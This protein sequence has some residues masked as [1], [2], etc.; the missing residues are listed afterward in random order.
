[1][2]NWRKFGRLPAGEKLVFLS[3]L[4][5]LPA[6]RLGL[7]LLGLRRVL[8]LL[9]THPNYGT[10]MNPGGAI[11][12]GTRDAYGARRTARLVAV[13]A[14]FA[15]G[16]C[17]ARSIVLVRLLEWQGIHAQ[18]RIGVR[19]DENGFEAH[20]WVENAGTILNDGQD[21]TEHF[22]AFDG[23]FALVRGNGR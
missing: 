14:G 9:E 21:V 6:V 7:R 18:L 8:A 15:G 23:N 22:A 4:V 13:A 12:V 11:P 3:A 10:K 19:R 20:A 5:L 16:S 1:M 17:L 2:S